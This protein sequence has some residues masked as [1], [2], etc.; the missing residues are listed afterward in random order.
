M[1]STFFEILSPCEQIFG[2]HYRIARPKMYFSSS[3]PRVELER[4][5]RLDF[6]R[7]HIELVAILLFWDRSLMTQ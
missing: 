5:S 6:R 4:F 3:V 1:T 2:D 7:S